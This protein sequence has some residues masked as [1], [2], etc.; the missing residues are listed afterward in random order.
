QSKAKRMADVCRLID[1]GRPP[2]LLVRVGNG[3]FD[4]HWVVAIAYKPG[5][6]GVADP[7]EPYQTEPIWIS[8]QDLAGAMNFTHSY[9]ELGRELNRG[10]SGF[11]LRPYRGTMVVVGERNYEPPGFLES[12]LDWLTKPFRFLFDVLKYLFDLAFGSGVD[13]GAGS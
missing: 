12:L 4:Y 11:L 1:E 10:V 8:W 5:H 7:A 2:I 6:V 9:A 3:E 13:S